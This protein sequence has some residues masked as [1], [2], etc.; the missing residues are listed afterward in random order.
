MKRGVFVE[1]SRAL[2]GKRSAA[3]GIFL[4]ALLCAMK[5][6]AGLL[7]KSVAVMADAA[8]NLSDALGAVVTLFSMRVAQKPDDK[9]HPFGH[10]RME[11]VGG[12]VVG[13]LILFVGYELFKGG[14][15][16]ILNPK[17]LAFS[18]ISFVLMGV[19]ATV[20]LG[21]Y[22]Y[23]TAVDKKIHSLAMKAAAKDSL[24]DVMATGGIILSMAAARLFHVKIDG[25]AGVLAAL[26]VLKAG[27]DVCR[28]TIDRLL[29]GKPDR[30]LALK[31]EKALLSYEGILG[32]HDMVLHDYGPG[33]CVASVHA[34][35]SAEADIVA[36]H[37]LIDRAEREIG[38][39]Y[40]LPICI[41]MDPIITDDIES[42][43]VKAQIAAFL[44]TED[45]RLKLHDFRRVPGDMQENLIFDV[46]LPTEYKEENALK[47]KLEAY[48]RTLNSR[49]RCIIHFDRDYFQ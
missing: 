47:E 13:L 15:E 29:G 41:H 8:N 32:L 27:F 1:E 28:E 10:G 30:E 26:L 48:A 9:E 42:N 14:I 37:E 7:T 23:Y 24:S 34:E 12:L 6:T 3:I 5:L 49:Y 2:K 45:R 35:V 46:V 11:Y 36:I 25:Y 40:N 18:F 39:R 44:K 22:F 16:S 21:M 19:S 31:A 33:R 38:E 4:N 17:E 20:K 43:A